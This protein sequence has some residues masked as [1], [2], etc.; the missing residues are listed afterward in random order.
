[1]RKP[2][3]SWS[4][5]AFLLSAAS[6]AQTERDLSYRWQGAWVLLRVHS[7]S[8]CQGFYTDNEIRG[9]LVLSK[10]KHRF[11]AGELATVHKVDLKRR[12][13]EV[14]LDL[15]EPLL[16]SYRDGPFTLYR[17]LRC[18]VELQMPRSPGSDKTTRLDELDA[19][20]AEV[21]ERH[22]DSQAARE[23]QSWNRRIREPYPEDY[24]ETLAEHQVWKAREINTAVQARIEESVEEAARIIA[25][26]D[27]DPSY[28]R[29]FAEGI[30]EAQEKYFGDCE[31][32]L[33]SSVYSFVERAPRGSR[34]AWRKGYE[35]GQE[36]VFHLE[37]GRRLRNCFV[38][39]PLP[40]AGF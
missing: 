12:K 30:E 34:K 39:V 25:D 19:L 6:S 14:L 26:F 17:E 27:D 37:V 11:E 10:G 21:L 7:Y 23:S 28:Q 33:E 8:G 3:L 38:P 13:V 18:K 4:L 1:M 29:G 35:A 32:L 5:V 16:V 20:L 22:P 31:A 24:E 36:L 40:R 2:S 9:D 15:A